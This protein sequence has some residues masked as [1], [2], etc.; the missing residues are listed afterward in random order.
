MLS[1]RSRAGDR[2]SV[3]LWVIIFT[4]AVLVLV[5]LIVDGGQLMNA[6]ERAADVAEQAARAAANDVNVVDL[7]AGTVAIDPGA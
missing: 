1:R 3:A 7:R 5:A 2:G 6:K 4:F